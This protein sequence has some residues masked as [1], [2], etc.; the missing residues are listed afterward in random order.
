MQCDRS[1]VDWLQ[2]L[3]SDIGFRARP[4]V[5]WSASSRSLPI[6][7]TLKAGEDA[8]GALVLDGSNVAEAVCGFTAELQSLLKPFIGGGLPPCPTHG[9]SLVA[10]QN[11]DMLEWRCTEGDFS[12]ALGEYEESLWPPGAD[13]RDAAPMLASRLTRRGMR[14]WSLE[15]T[16]GE[17]GWVA[18]ITL[19]PG[20]DAGS[21]R[22]V[23]APMSAELHFAEP[24][25]TVLEDH[26]DGPRS[27]PYRS[28]S[29]R[30]ALQQ[31]ALLRGILR[32]AT[33]GDNCDFLVE[34][35]HQQRVRVRLLPDHSILPG[36]DMIV[37]DHLGK[38]FATDGDNVE[39]G[40]GFARVSPVEGEP[41]CFHAWEVRVLQ[42]R[43]RG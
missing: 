11:L 12:C 36:E 41:V 17:S 37:A 21:V 13:E 31:S 43:G 1:P 7:V 24:A 22:D 4:A 42:K 38:P 27:V 25:Y 2:A 23:V 34:G 39:C 28:L 5:I 32:R 3:F 10:K 19:Q 29:L 15:V 18:K 8:V 6:T 33:D 9:L 35:Q 30:G 20:T 16:R 40:G 26:A 14:W